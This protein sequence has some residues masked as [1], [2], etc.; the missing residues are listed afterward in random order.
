[1]YWRLVATVCRFRKGQIIKRQINSRE[2]VA[3][4]ARFLTCLYYVVPI[5]PRLNHNYGSPVS[6]TLKDINKKSAKDMK[7]GPQTDNRALNSGDHFLFHP[8]GRSCP[9]TGRLLDFFDIIA[10]DITYLKSSS[11]ALKRQAKRKSTCHL[12]GIGCSTENKQR[13]FSNQNRN[14]RIFTILL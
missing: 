12:S 1:M 3:I 14:S 13:Q 2:R 11:P 5:D 8:T 7:I 10:D 6:R 9:A 4:N